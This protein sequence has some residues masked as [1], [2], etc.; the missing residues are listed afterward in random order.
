V[1][2]SPTKGKKL[3]ET[4]RVC[5]VLGANVRS[6]GSSAFLFPLSPSFNSPSSPPSVLKTAAFVQPSIF[7]DVE[8][9]ELVRLCPS[10]RSL[11]SP[12][13]SFAPLI[14][15]RRPLAAYPATLR[16]LRLGAPFASQNAVEYDSEGAAPPVGSVSNYLQLLDCLP[17]GLTS[18]KFSQLYDTIL[19]SVPPLTAMPLNR[20]TSLFLDFVT[21]SPLLLDWLAPSTAAVSLEKVQI[22][23]VRGLRS[24]D[25]VKFVQRVGGGLKEF[26][27]KPKGSR[28]G[29]KLGNELVG[30]V[31]LLLSLS[32]SVL[33]TLLSPS[34][35]PSQP[36][37]PHSRRQSLRT[38]Y[39]LSPALLPPET[40]YLPP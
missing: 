22:W 4:L 15:G 17:E 35:P 10:L 19:P 9:D 27:F 24:E 39:L 1:V 3:L 6:M 8:Q 18:I 16:S 12:F 33:T 30:C 21:V 32:Q 2:D 31:F 28:Q 29:T 20:L 13:A 25:I 38:R 40:C 34:Q 37:L 11:D 36:H 14:D 5:P 26:M 23:C 7:A